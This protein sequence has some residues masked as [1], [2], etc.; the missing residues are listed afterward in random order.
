MNVSQRVAWNLRRIRVSQK[1]SQ[2]NL[3]VDA[4]IDRTYVGRLERGV[5]NPSVRVLEKLARALDIDLTELFVI[6][7]QNAT[8][9]KTLPSGRHKK[10]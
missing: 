5:E 7:P 3:A 4:Q 10:K 1:I 6:P 2:E 8:L 9:L